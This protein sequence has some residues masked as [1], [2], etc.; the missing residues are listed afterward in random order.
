MKK[1]PLTDEQLI[2][3][4]VALQDT[5]KDIEF[6]IKIYKDALK[7]R[8]AFK[9]WGWLNLKDGNKYYEQEEEAR[10]KI[11]FDLHNKEVD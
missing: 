4:I 5:K 7:S 11:L 6:R 2:G 9:N 8:K 3:Y 1:K 10:L